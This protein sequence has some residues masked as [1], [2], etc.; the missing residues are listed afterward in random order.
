MEAVAN[1]NLL[2]SEIVARRARRS[3][4]RMWIAGL[5][6][7]AGAVVVGMIGI[8]APEVIGSVTSERGLSAL[9]AEIKSIEDEIPV[10]E[11][12]R[13][14]MDK[15]LDVLETLEDRP[16]WGVML[17]YLHSVL[18]EGVVLSRC[19]LKWSGAG[20]M[21]LELSGLCEEPGQERSLVVGLEASALFDETTLVETRRQSV[22]GQ[23]RITFEILCRYE[24]APAVEVTP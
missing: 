4:L 22:G 11:Q 3:V 14:M 23:E 7:T 6:F 13:E 10:L 21:T 18:G 20:A 8:R 15:R 17:A 12:Q 2:P 1:I 9:N 19:E 16:D 24:P 5:C